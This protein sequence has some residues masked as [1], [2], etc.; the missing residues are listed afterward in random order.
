MRHISWTLGG[1][2]AIGIGACSSATA[3]HSVP[4]VTVVSGAGQR[5][6]INATLPQPLVIEVHGPRGSSGSQAIQ[7]HR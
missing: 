7:F 6:A 5:D 2:V 3:P 4:G 1:C